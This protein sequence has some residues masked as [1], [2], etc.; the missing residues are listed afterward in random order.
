MSR[1]R[2]RLKQLLL[3]FAVVS[4]LYADV[5]PSRVREVTRGALRQRGTRNGADIAPH[6]VNFAAWLVFNDVEFIND[7]LC[8]FG[9]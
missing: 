2:L 5:P 1:D 4:I 8:F 7:L 3:S 9:P 6:A